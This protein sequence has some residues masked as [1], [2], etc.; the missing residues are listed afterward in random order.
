MKHV[1]IGTAGH[2][3]HGKTTLVKALTGIDTDRLEEEKRRGVTIEPGF[4]YID[5]EDGSRAGVV[6][7]PGHERFIRNM[8]AGAGGIDLTMLV[9]AADEGVMPQ[10]REHLGILTQLGIDDG[11]V[12]V[13]KTDKVDDEWLELVYD[14]ISQLVSDTF[15][16]KKPVI[17]VSAYL[18][19]GID[20]L[21]K[22]IYERIC[23]IKEKD[24]SLPFRLPIDRVFLVDGFGIVVTG[25]LI[26]GS[27]KVGDIAEMLPSGEKAPVKSIQVHGENADFA[28]AGQRVAI[29]LGGV[30]R[31]GIIRGDV[32]AADKTVNITTAIEIKL[33]V[34]ADS[35]RTIK[36]GSELH[37]FH[38]T[39]TLLSKVILLDRKELKS[40][41]SCYARLKLKEPLPCK[42]ND[43]LVLRFL[44]P[45][46]TIG[47]G[48]ILDAMSPDRIL[49]GKRAIANLEIRERGDAGEVAALTAEQL[50]KV[51]SETELCKR[52]DLDKK[53]CSVAI[54]TLV[55]SG[56]VQE[57]LPGKFISAAIQSELGEKCKQLLADYHVKYPLRA[58][59]NIAELRQ[60][61]MPGI[62]T[63]DANAVLN[64]LCSGGVIVLSDKAATLPDYKITYTPLQ[65]KIKN[66]LVDELTAAGYDVPA[67]DELAALFSKNEKFTWRFKSTSSDGHS[68]CNSG[69]GMFVNTFNP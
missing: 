64:T 57:L 42:R 8:L 38:G 52:A 66:K 37:L 55:A 62:D 33:N 46:E 13:T 28:Y 36:T 44:S 24:I 63:A 56:I 34:L 26:E 60:K 6:D 54:K 61:L 19:E 50:G 30:K 5:F 35:E 31:G 49:R 47:G 41:E 4:A 51:F 18:G 58:G 16:D 27:V 40:G 14:D 65:S 45:L 23:C 59:M 22:T 11:I 9:I 67:P 48:V 21:K 2:V 53:T 20:V 25:T 68:I 69:S 3:D 29:S 7:V 1:V 43:R 32:I 17:P 15:L 10:T 12:V 39:R